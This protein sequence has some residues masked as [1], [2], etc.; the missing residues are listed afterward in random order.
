M[1]KAV[2]TNSYM[3]YDGKLSAMYLVSFLHPGNPNQSL[4]INPEQ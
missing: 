2:L 1:R 4:T 3:P